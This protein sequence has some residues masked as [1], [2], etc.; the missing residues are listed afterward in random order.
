MRRGMGVGAWPHGDREAKRPRTSAAGERGQGINTLLGTPPLLLPCL[1]AECSSDV[2]SSRKSPWL[3]LVVALFPPTGT[4]PWVTASVPC[5]FP[6]RPS[7]VLPSVAGPGASLLPFRAGVRPLSGR[8]SPSA[9][10]ALPIPPAP[11]RPRTPAPTALC[12]WEES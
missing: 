9:P 6:W 5:V 4:P 3:S 7:P 12:L 8:P 1:G 11:C 10:E 2:P